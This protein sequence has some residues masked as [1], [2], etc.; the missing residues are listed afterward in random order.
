MAYAT[1]DQDC[2]LLPEQVVL[3]ALKMGLQSCQANANAPECNFVDLVTVGHDR[4][5]LTLMMQ[6]FPR[7]TPT[8]TFELNSVQQTPV[9]LLI[10][11]AGPMNVDFGHSWPTLLS[12]AYRGKADVIVRTIA[13]SNSDWWLLNARQ[14]L[15]E[16]KHNAPIMV[17][18]SL[19]T[20]EFEAGVDMFVT[21]LS[22]IVRMTKTTFPKCQ[23]MLMNPSI[24]LYSEVCLNVAC[25]NGVV[26]LKQVPHHQERNGLKGMNVCAPNHQSLFNELESRIA[27][28]CPL[29]TPQVLP[30]IFP[31]PQRSPKP[32]P[33]ACLIVSVKCPIKCMHPKSR[34]SRDSGNLTTRNGDIVHLWDAYRGSYT[35]QEWFWDGKL[36][37][38]AKCPSKCIHLASGWEKDAFNGDVCHLWDVV[39]GSY[40]AQEWIYDGKVFRSVKCSTKCIHLAS[41]WEKGSYNGDKCHLWD[42]IDG[43]YT[44]QEWKIELI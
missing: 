17:V 16:W 23:I 25:E 31:S 14:I 40:P 32:A 21:N 8:Y 43:S 2:L 28:T 7:L 18:I 39:E 26:A 6:L 1:H 10:G 30:T 29:W 15:R 20:T 4:L 42:V 19:G 44:A 13:N 9:I 3:D 22:A 11:D 12:R 36:I 33:V 34:Y 24:D 41:G 27:N 5:C 35:G 37:R 38:S